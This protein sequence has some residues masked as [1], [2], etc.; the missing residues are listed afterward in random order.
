MP[1]SHKIKR[2]ACFFMYAFTSCPFTDLFEHPD[3]SFPRSDELLYGTLVKIISILPGSWCHVRTFYR[4]EG[5]L[6]RK[7]LT[8]L[9]QWKNRCLEKKLERNGISEEEGQFCMVRKRFCDVLKSPNIKSPLLISIPKGSFV[10]L[11]PSLTKNT[12]E[13]GYLRLLLL[14][15]QVGYCPENFLVPIGDTRTKYSGVSDKVPSF[16][17]PEEEQE[18]REAV[19]KTALTYLDTPY[20]WGGKSPAGIDCSGL[21][22]MSYLLRG[23]ILFRD[24]KIKPGFPVHPIPVEQKKPGDLLYFPGHVAMYL[25]NDQYIH[26]TAKKGVSGVVINSLNPVSSNYRE[27][28]PQSLVCAGSIF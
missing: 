19:Q 20:R 1:F 23:V 17:I 7:D 2:K 16:K 22:F 24:A 5:Y 21:V 8:L 6:Q 28:L 9:S 12:E 15:G 27:D 11:F 3:N 18:F 26:A 10:F 14:D 13:H 25:G 4:Y